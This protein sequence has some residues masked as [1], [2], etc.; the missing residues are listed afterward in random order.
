M[1]GVILGASPGRPSAPRDLFS[2]ILPVLPTA[3]REFAKSDNATALFY[4]YQLAGRPLVPAQLSIRIVD[5][6]DAALIKDA[7]TIAVDR[8]IAAEAPD[9][10]RMPTTG[11]RSTVGP[12]P[13]PVKRPDAGSAALRAAEVQYPVPINRLPPGRYLLTFEAT[14]GETVLR[15]D[16]QFSIR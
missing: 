15:R 4:L 16:V 10:S 14:M 9:V 1:S 2:N 3:Q 8:F 6:H 5:V 7:Q 12:P 11:G 13:A